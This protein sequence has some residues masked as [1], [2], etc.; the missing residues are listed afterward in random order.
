MCSFPLMWCEI[1]HPNYSI[2]FSDDTC[3]SSEVGLDSHQYVDTFMCY[4][5][6]KQQLIRKHVCTVNDLCST[7]LYWYGDWYVWVKQPVV[8][9]YILSQIWGDLFTF[10]M[11]DRQKWQK[12]F[13]GG[14][15]SFYFSKSCQQSLFCS[16]LHIPNMSPLF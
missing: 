12:A 5:K 15:P 10:D 11:P 3:N 9:S 2:P 6:S 13:S 4:S 8:C 7:Y 16:H 1:S 14:M